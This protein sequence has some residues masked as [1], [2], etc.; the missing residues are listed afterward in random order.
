MNSLMA[1]YMQTFPNKMKQKE[2][3]IVLFKHNFE[4]VFRLLTCMD[5]YMF[6]I[7]MSRLLRQV[8]FP[9]S[10]RAVDLVDKI[11]RLAETYIATDMNHLINETEAYSKKILKEDW[12]ILSIIK[13]CFSEYN[14]GEIYMQKNNSLGEVVDV[15]V[16]DNEMKYSIA[17]YDT[18]P[19]FIK[20]AKYLDKT[21]KRVI[22]IP[23]I[24]E[25]RRANREEYEQE[26]LD[27]L[28]MVSYISLRHR[29]KLL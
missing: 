15:Y 21:S 11:N 4:A 14:D 24:T 28:S 5:L 25:R 17:K 22:D 9:V 3:L 6:S 10:K 8:E 19:E 1:L 26:K 2:E 16:Y 27:N 18:F 7:R 29:Q 13:K 23:E 12:P 20:S